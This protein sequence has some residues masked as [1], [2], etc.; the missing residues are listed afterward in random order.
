LA[1]SDEDQTL[2]PE[3]E[4]FIS[5]LSQDPLCIHECNEQILEELYGMT[6]KESQGDKDHIETWF[7]IV[8][9]TQYHSIF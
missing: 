8:T 6:T 2:E 3:I 7:Q 9:R 4:E 1:T 5:Y